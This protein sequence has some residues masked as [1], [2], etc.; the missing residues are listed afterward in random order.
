MHRGLTRLE[1]LGFHLN[2]DLGVAMSGVQADMP[3]PSSDHVDLNA[4]LE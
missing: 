4:R 1:R 3:E 2:G